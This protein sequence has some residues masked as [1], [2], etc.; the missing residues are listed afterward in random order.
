MEGRLCGGVGGCGVVRGVWIGVWRGVWRGVE[1]C[2]ERC[3]EVFLVVNLR[4][5]LV[6]LVSGLGVS[7]NVSCQG[8][9]SG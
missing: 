9:L 3:L 7:F 1:R 6:L 8:E 4:F 2:L 5:N